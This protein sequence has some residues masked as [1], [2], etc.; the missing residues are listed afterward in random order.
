MMRNYMYQLFLWLSLLWL[1]IAPCPAQTRGEAEAQQIG[2][3][4]LKRQGVL[5]SSARGEDLECVLRGGSEG[6]KKARENGGDSWF[7]FN[8]PK[9][10]QGAFVLVS[11]EGNSEDAVLGY[12]LEERFNVTS[13]PA[14]VKAWLN[15]Y[16]H[17]VEL[18]RH[19]N[20]LEKGL[21]SGTAI[22]PLLGNIQW[23]QL[24]PY[25]KFTPHWKGSDTQTPVGCVATAMG[26]IMRYHKWPARA[27]RHLVE[28]KPEGMNFTVRQYLGLHSY[29]WEQMPGMVTSQSPEGQQDA[30]ARLLYEVG[31]A[32]GM[33]YNIPENGG[34]G[35]H[36]SRV[37]EALLS[38]FNYSKRLYYTMRAF[39]TRQQWEA[40]VLK[41]L[42]AG[43]PVYYAGSGKQGGHAFVCDGYDGEGRFHFNWGW[44]GMSNG[45][46]SL[47]MLAPEGLG[48]GG[49]A[50]G[51]VTW[52]EVILGIEPNRED[53]P[54]R[55]TPCFTLQGIEVQGKK[56]MPIEMP[57]ADTVYLKVNYILSHTPVRDFDVDLS[58]GIFNL[59]GELVKQQFLGT[60]NETRIHTG[61]NYDL[62]QQ[63]GVKPFVLFTDL[64]DGQY[65]V[66][67]LVR[68]KGTE[69]WYRA[70]MYQML[71]RRLLVE[72][73]DNNITVNREQGKHANI[74]VELISK[75]IPAETPTLLIV[76]V[77]NVGT[78]D[79][80][81][82]F[83]LLPNDQKF[84]S[85]AIYSNVISL[86]A[87]E[88][89]ILRIPIKRKETAD[90]Q[91][92]LYF[93]YGP[94]AEAEWITSKSPFS[95]REDG[96]QVKLSFK[97]TG[98]VEMGERPQCQ[99]T[100][101]QS[102]VQQLEKLTFKVTLSATDSKPWGDQLLYKLM[103]N[104]S[105]VQ[106][107]ATLVP[108]VLVSDQEP[109]T[110]SFSFEVPGFTPGVYTLVVGTYDA[111]L[112]D[113]LGEFS[114]TSRI[115]F[116][117]E[118]NPAYPE[119]QPIE[120]T[121]PPQNTVTPATSPS[122][123]PINVFPNPWHQTLSITWAHQD[124]IMRVELY[125][126]LGTLIEVFPTIGVNSLEIKGENIPSGIY[127]LR[128]IGKEGNM[129]RIVVKQ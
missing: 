125:S 43:R 77:K 108:L 126:P 114:G 58:F 46:F 102:T 116:T 31:I 121:E 19:G 48:T 63:Y 54:K 90:G 18:Q 109:F 50:G 124:E 23:D 74:E 51:F 89:R 96:E 66:E 81:S 38:Y 21:R 128:I 53:S 4:F 73:K 64:P 104:D 87:G 56:Q 13:L 75:E 123:I 76:K 129:Q 44:S 118:P 88:E 14:H 60:L 52:H 45:Y 98:K 68:E 117:I 16:T 119:I 27:K 25:N 40:M 106:I 85:Q 33:N 10:A 100:T 111:N 69:D 22:A 7:L 6:A 79:Y 8:T 61:A 95:L 32:S 78:G 42:Q 65:T 2:A 37:A 97:L 28:Y 101:T 36:S 82:E 84:I 72:V 11:S 80:A 113:H 59:K 62:F 9:D 127:I 67:M 120:P 103:L 55:I 35:C 92:V 20:A 47:Q 17:T 41:E 29:D 34:S 1:A 71:P 93:G 83:H 39:Y 70:L 57:K 91:D 15:E 5:K 105:T 86:A 107:P 30:V 24:A 99:L 115:Q 110:Q 3:A 94:L 122:I 112:E 49:G 12:S 26:Q